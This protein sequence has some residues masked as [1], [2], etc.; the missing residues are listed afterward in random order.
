MPGYLLSL[1]VPFDID[2]PVVGPDRPVRQKPIIVYPDHALESL[3][4][5]SQVPLCIR[6]IGHVILFA[7]FRAGEA[8]DQPLD[9]SVRRKLDTDHLPI[10]DHQ[11]I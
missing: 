9:K 6:D 5:S 11:V 3:E 8:F 2:V 4:D 1:S 10:V 7:P